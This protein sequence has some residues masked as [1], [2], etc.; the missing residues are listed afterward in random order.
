MTAIHPHSRFRRGGAR[1]QAQGIVLIIA[2][3]LLVVIGLSSAVVVR[4]GLFTETGAGN[5]R[6][7]SLAFNAAE[8]A[9]RDCEAQLLAW[10]RSSPR[11]AA[12]GWIQADPVVRPITAPGAWRQRANW[13]GARIR[14]VPAATLGVTINYPTPPQCMV[15]EVEVIGATVDTELNFEVTAWGFSPDYQRNG[16]DTVGGA[17]VLLQSVIRVLK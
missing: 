17:E 11:P 9:L 8:L 16:A 7:Q 6:A 2:L 14:T 3:V 10:L 5:Q 13:A 15:E 4:S 1:R 12:P